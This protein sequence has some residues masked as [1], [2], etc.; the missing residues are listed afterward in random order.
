MAKNSTAILLEIYHDTDIIDNNSEPDMLFYFNEF[1][2]H[3][4]S[5][6]QSVC[7]MSKNI[8]VLFLNSSSVLDSHFVSTTT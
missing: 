3:S 6:R 2:E 5:D 7:G 1:K 4:V 8:F